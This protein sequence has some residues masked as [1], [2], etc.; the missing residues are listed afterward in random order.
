MMTDTQATTVTESMLTTVDNPFDPFT[1]FEP[2][3]SFDV[4]HGYCT[5]N[6]LARLTMTAEDL[7]PSDQD[8]ALENAMDEI[9]RENVSGMHRK[10]TK[11]ISIVS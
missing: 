2:W 9:V 8:V 10:V 1:Q 6:L 11:E 7:S 3:Y 5:L 4:T